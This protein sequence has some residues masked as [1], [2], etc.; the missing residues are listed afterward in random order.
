MEKTI[1]KQHHPPDLVAGVPQEVTGQLRPVVVGGVAWRHT[2][3]ALKHPNFRLFFIGQ[4]VSLIG[5]WMQTTAQGWLVYELTGSKALLGTVAAAGSLPLLLL[6]PWGG[7]VADRHPKRTLVCLTQTAMMVLAFALAGLVWSGLIQP[8]HIVVLS[9][10]GGVAMAFDLPARQSFMVEITSH[11]DLMN[12]VALNSSMV[13]GARVVGPAVAGFLMARAGMAMCFFLNGLS[14]IAVIAGLLVMRLPRHEAPAKPASTK[15]HLLE[16]FKYV[17]GH[18]RVRRLMILFG[19]VGI[20]GWSYAILLPAYARDILHLN[21]GG[22]STLL[23]ANGLGALL[24]ALTVATFGS[25]MQ[26]RHLIFG[27][28]WLFC[29][30]LI[31]LAVVCWYPLVL[32]SLVLGGWGMMLYFATT[33]TLIQ[34]NVS[35]KM[36]GRVMGIWGLV[37]GGMM[38]IGGLASGFLS[39]AVGVPWTIIVGALI[40]ATACLIMWWQVRRHPSPPTEPH[41]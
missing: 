10:L 20:F 8:W 33:N 11:K 40:C 32:L 30:M 14:F 27:G 16:G 19:I 17:A 31:M 5:T 13:N 22:Y 26:T 24:G 15:L 3:S 23:C 6:S 12:A 29:A 34:T 25:R 37:F 21:E 4:L 18:Q 1:A 38:P 9:A 28:L 39:Q 36:R 41:S 35:S 7:S 2:F